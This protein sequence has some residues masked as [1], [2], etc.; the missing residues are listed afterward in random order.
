MKLM[1]FL[2]SQRL[3]VNVNVVVKYS[4]QE[5]EKNKE[6]S[7]AITNLYVDKDLS[8]VIG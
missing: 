1:F 4:L 3:L 7:H 2:G 6:N 8:L 5:V